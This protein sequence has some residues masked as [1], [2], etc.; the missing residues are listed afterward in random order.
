MI[1]KLTLCAAVLGL[2]ISSSAQN[3]KCASHV[4]HNQRL[5]TDFQYQANR[6][7]IQNAS[8]GNNAKK[9]ATVY[10]IP[11]VIHIIHNGESV[12]SG[13]NISDAQVQSAMDALNKDFRMTNSDT[14]TASH[15]FYSLSADA[16]IEFCLAKKDP[17]GL[18]TTGVVRYNKGKS[19]W[20][21]TDFDATVKPAT[22]WDRTKYMNIWVVTIGGVDDGTLGYATFP[23][24]NDAT[25][26]VV[27]GTTYFGT[28]GNVSPGF[29]LNRTATHEVGHYLN[30]YHIWGDATCGDDEVT[31]TPPAEQD[32]AG[33]PSFPHNVSSSCSPG[34]NGEMYMNYMDYTDDACMQLFTEGQKTRMRSALSV[35]RASLLTS[36]VCNA[37]TSAAAISSNATSI[38]PNPAV[39]EVTINTG[40]DVSVSV[41]ISDMNGTVVFA[42]KTTGASTT[43]STSSLAAGNYVVV[44]SSDANIIQKTLTVIK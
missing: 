9:M 20:E 43:I 22:Q 7:A 32:N 26:G 18:A 30:L 24:T 25:D 27:M 38:Y 10:T 42:G 35:S 2:A 34:T 4:L 36:D 3:Q 15:P 40:T 23:G 8:E 33:C 6:L 17:N 39:N 14:L 37:P 12:G 41:S 31:D 21:I 5:A 28:T 29:D 44:L 19:E 11:V 1:K 16:E 13:A